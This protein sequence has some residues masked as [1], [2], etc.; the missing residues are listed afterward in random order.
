MLLPYLKILINLSL[1]ISLS[2]CSA[3]KEIMVKR[4]VISIAKSYSKKTM[5]ISVSTADPIALRTLIMQGFQLSICK[6]TADTIYLT[7]P[8]AKD[9]EQIIKHHPGE[10]K[11]TIQDNHEIRPDLRPIIAALNNSKIKLINGNETSMID[12]LLVNIDT[13]C[14]VLFY[15]IKLPYNIIANKISTI[16]LHSSPTDRMINR[17]EFSSQGYQ[18]LSNQVQEQPFG[19]DRNNRVTDTQ[20]I[21]DYK[22]EF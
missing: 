18:S 5:L 13:E 8:S 12:G 2:S 20:R 19:A 9:V 22:Y 21:I 15:T 4:G 3:T 16:I 7:C 11:A 14:G 17:N 10:V 1:L 6:N